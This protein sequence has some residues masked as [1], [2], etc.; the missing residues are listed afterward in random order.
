MNKTYDQYVK[1]LE[2]VYKK[3]YCDNGICPHFSECSTNMEKPK[4]KCDYA[5]RVGAHYGDAKYKVVIVGQESK[6]DHRK[7]VPPVS[8]LEE[9]HNEHYRKTLYTLAMILNGEQ[10]DNCSQENLKKYEKL[11][12][13]FC[14]TNYFKCAFSDDPNKN[15]NLDHSKA[16]KENCYKL[17][18]EELRVLEPDLLVVQGRDTTEN[19]GTAPDKAFKKGER[20]WGNKNDKISL[21]KH[22]LNEKPFFI[23]YSYHPSSLQWNSTKDDLKEAIDKFREQ[24]KK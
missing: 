24:Y 21:Y 12:T 10:P 7:L 5:T 16:M 2:L 3:F 23:L 9:A 20:I 17:L 4:F 15:Q 1:D 11:L 18:L 22:T 6:E 8:K 13:H 14:L 19:F